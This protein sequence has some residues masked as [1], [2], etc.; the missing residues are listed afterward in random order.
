MKQNQLHVTLNKKKLTLTAQQMTFY[1][2]SKIVEARDSNHNYYYLFFYKNDYIN[3]TSSNQIGI[4]SYVH[5]A[6]THGI[7]MDGEH[8]LTVALIRQ[9][10][11]FHLQTFN[12]LFKK[13]QQKYTE[14]ETALIFT[15]FDS[16]TAQDSIKKLLKKT[17]YQYRRNGQMLA[18][19]QLLLIYIHHD[20]KDSFAQDMI[21]NMQ[22]RSYH[23]SYENLNQVYIK[24]PL[25]FEIVSFD[26]LKN[27]KHVNLLL[28]L[29]KKQQ[30]WIDELALR[31]HLLNIDYSS[32]NF[33]IIQ[34]MITLFNEEEQTD[35]LQ[36]LSKQADNNPNLQ[37]TVLNHLIHSGRHNEAVDLVMTSDYQP[38][39]QQL[40]SIKISIEKADPS[41][42]TPLINNSNERLLQLVSNDHKTL[43][44][45]TT[46]FVSSFLRE[47]SLDTILQWFSPYRKAKIHLPIEQKLL[48]M[49]TLED[50]PDQQYA[51][52]QL[53]LEFHQFEKSV[54][55]FKW[56]MELNPSDPKPVQSLTK[57][58]N[59]IGNKEEASAY[60]QLL[61]QMQKTS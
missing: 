46:V 8:P 60:Q 47:H 48:K 27:K 20:K 55:C 49:Q 52:G 5:R 45:L 35:L 30:R 56:E 16:F 14:L 2:Q 28:E 24:D 32:E 13:L 50:D 21:N 44:S 3:G 4:N 43:E 31:I 23:Q 42:L 22:F 26:N 38:N 11:S 12:Q 6:F 40:E 15:F 9:H 51:L 7:H 36:L 33:A 58:L 59:E 34:E 17:Y 53:Y 18:A 10:D 37:E 29:Y 57:A 39:K 54:D 19:F 61:I 1:K 41:N 25:Q